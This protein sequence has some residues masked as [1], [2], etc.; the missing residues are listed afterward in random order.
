MGVEGAITAALE[1]VPLLAGHVYTAEAMRNESLFAFYR[2]RKDAPVGYGLSDG[3][4]PLREAEVELHAVAEGFGD[5]L[6][7]GE[8]IETAVAAMKDA[9][10]DIRVEE[11]RIEQTSP[12]LKEVE[13]NK[14]RR[15][16]V[17][18]M[19]YEEGAN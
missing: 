8:A 2:V 5:M 1:R 18:R 16:Y 9:A 3:A 17:L 14:Y 12:D 7:C 11:L 15:M 10:D 13:V 6:S 19:W 4:L